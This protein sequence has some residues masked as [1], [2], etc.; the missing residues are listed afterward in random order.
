MS[1]VEAPTD[2]STPG[3]Y[4]ARVKALVLCAAT[5]SWPLDRAHTGSKPLAPVA[6]RPIV[7][8]ALDAIAEAGI[9]DVGVVVGDARAELEAALGD[10]SQFGVRLTFIQQH[11]ARG[12][13]HC[14]Q[15]AREFLGDDDFLLYVGDNLLEDGVT[16]AVD[17]FR[18]AQRE[19]SG[20]PAA[21]V[22]LKKVE[23]PRQFGVAVLDPN[24]TVEAVL[25]K[26]R[27]PPSNLALVGVYLF[28]RRIHDAVRSID[29]SDDGDL[30]I[31][32]AIQHLLEHGQRV[33]AHSVDGWWLDTGRKD[34]LL[35]A[36]RLL[37]EQL[38][39]SVHGLVDS[40]SRVEGRVVIE[41][42]AKVIASTVRG[43]A[44]IGAG[45]VLE[46]A[47]VGP[48]TAIGPACTVLD[49]EVD[50]SVLLA[51]SR[52]EQAGRVVDSVIGRKA[53]VTRAPRPGTITVTLG[54]DAAVELA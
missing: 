35:E 33:A 22:L 44:I 49:T 29:P 17:A 3:S 50:H 34:P 1:R 15:L 51:G 8:H 7:F 4:A 12:V 31:A 36:N 14:V 11:E 43:P 10:G 39:R 30:E 47:F 20:P 13:A 46:N 54:D 2:R 40:R 28:D 32:A 9:H 21:M 23:D 45:T 26:P 41:A 53:S 18:H 6:N 27:I 19:L 5:A 38:E 42:G 48:F 37:L 24:G 25:D 16:G 52:L